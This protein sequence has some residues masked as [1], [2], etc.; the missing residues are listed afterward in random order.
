MSLGSW[1]PNADQQSADFSIDEKL[2]QQL[3]NLGDDPDLSRLQQ[4]LSAEQL[5][6]QAPLMRQDK[7]QWFA[8]AANFSD[9]EIIS[10]MRTLTLAEQLP[11]WQAGDKSPVIWLGKILKKR[12]CG[13]DR[14]L[15]L[16]IKQHSDNR[17]LPH[18]SLL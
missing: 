4:S 10:L 8:L 14:E 12:G 5:Q 1:D 13:I 11:G 16:W 7:E 6:C 9:E 2:L 17:F 18:G 3:I 15:Q